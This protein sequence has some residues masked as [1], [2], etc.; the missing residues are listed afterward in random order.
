MHDWL[1]GQGRGSPPAPKENHIPKRTVATKSEIE[2]A[3]LVGIELKRSQ[4][5]W[6]LKDSLEELALLAMTAGAEVVGTLTQ[7]LD[8]L[9]PSH[10]IGKGKLEE[11][12]AL[13][14]EL[15]S[16]LIIFDDELSPAQQR[17][18]DK[19]LGVKV[20]D[21]TALI[22]DIFAKRAHTHE[23]RLQVELAQLK[24]LLPRLAGLWPHLERLGGGIGTR[25][26]GETQIE[27]DRR[28]IEKRI[29][30]LQ[31]EIEN[32][33]KHRARYRRHRATTGIP[34][35]ALVGYT[36]A[37]KSTLLNALSHAD[38]FVEDKLFATLDTTTRRLTLPNNREV[39][40]SD[41]GGFIQKLPPM[42][43]AAFKA[44]LE[45]L[46]EADV[47]LHVIDITHA[48]ASEQ[49]QTVDDLL[50]ELG[51]DDKPR[52]IAINKVDMLAKSIGLSG[53][54]AIDY[55]VRRMGG[56][57]GAVTPIAAARGW[58]LNQLRNLFAEVLS[59]KMVNIT[60]EIPH[61]AAELVN[62]FHRYGS[63][64]REEHTESGSVISGK[65]PEQMESEF[66]SIRSPF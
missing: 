2:K 38:V 31:K 39:L 3:L 17:N 16:D 32:V 15:G 24:Y 36:N 58:G 52:I 43:V 35:I 37:G 63:I 18:L 8:R 9:S 62:R 12:G 4:S 11:L 47:L 41:T 54:E 13:K 21:R 61:S 10:L 28:I 50:V 30:Y 45:E 6:A 46:S 26:P 49:G 60:V 22:L 23:G 5:T 64:K 65:I 51:L 66:K 40:I 33:R 56:N 1:N 44:T 29:K 19:A 48:N 20:L 27:S 7:K 55:Y 53:E 34:V 25:G 57:V 14:D 59:Q 42:V